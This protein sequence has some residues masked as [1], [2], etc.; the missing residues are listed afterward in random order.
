MTHHHIVEHDLIGHR[1][2]L[3]QPLARVAVGDRHR[4]LMVGV[5][6]RDGLDLGLRSGLG[7]RPG[8]GSRSASGWSGL[9]L[10]LG[11]ELAS[12]WPGLLALRLG[13]DRIR[14]T[15]TCPPRCTMVAGAALVSSTISDRTC[16]WSY[17]VQ[18]EG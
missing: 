6:V 9:G 3:A 7:S 15:V 14:V 8:L 11:L 5:R 10:E 18:G 17:K 12:G 4:D 13:L 16:Q 1:H 2:A